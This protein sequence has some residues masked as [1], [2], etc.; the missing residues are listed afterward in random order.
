IFGG[1]ILRL[2]RARDVGE[3]QCWALL[4]VAAHEVGHILFG[5]CER[6]P[7]SIV[8]RDYFSPTYSNDRQ[9]KELEADFFAG[10]ILASLGAPKPYVSGALQLLGVEDDPS[11]LYPA[12]AERK[13]VMLRGWVANA[14]RATGIM[15]RTATPFREHRN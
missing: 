13:E 15:P 11:G 6:L 1:A 12:A 4:A 3:P 14:T 7:D 5:H 9:L 10:H 8:T 2:L